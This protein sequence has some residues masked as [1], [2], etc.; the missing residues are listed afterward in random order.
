ME[1]LLGRALLNGE[2]ELPLIVPSWGLALLLLF[3]LLVTSCLDLAV[4][5]GE[6][7]LVKHN[8]LGA[9]AILRHLKVSQ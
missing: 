3:F 5:H 8:Q 1:G 4:H 2:E 7:A 9:V 6:H